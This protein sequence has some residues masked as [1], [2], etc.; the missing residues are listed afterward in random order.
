MNQSDVDELRRFVEEVHSAR[1]DPESESSKVLQTYIDCIHLIQRL[2][3]KVSQD[4]SRGELHRQEQREELAT[5]EHRVRSLLAEEVNDEVKNPGLREQVLSTLQL[6]EWEAA[7]LI[8]ERQDAQYA[9]LSKM[10][11]KPDP[12][13][14]NNY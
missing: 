2:R 7:R 10:P 6:Q 8:F 13:D 3:H 11:S 14:I 5:A 1:Q 12:D 9:A 4:A